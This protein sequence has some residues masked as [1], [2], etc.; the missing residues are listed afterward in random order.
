MTYWATLWYAG[1]VVVQLGYEGQNQNDCEML[2]TMM[3]SDIEQ[4]YSDPSKLD[5]S[6]KALFP[7]NEF[8]VSCET[9]VLP[10]DEKYGITKW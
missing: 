3:L 8:T 6:T 4:T 5:D 10:I 1:A 9:T 2:R 7:T